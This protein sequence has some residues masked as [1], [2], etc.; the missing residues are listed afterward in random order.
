M[1]C[2]AFRVDVGWTPVCSDVSDHLGLLIQAI[3]NGYA[4]HRYRTDTP[5][6]SMTY[7][8]ITTMQYW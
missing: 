3:C 4:L 7:Y 1:C 8:I 2:L 6:Q 5:W